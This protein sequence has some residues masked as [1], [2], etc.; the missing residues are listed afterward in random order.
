MQGEVERGG[1]LIR[2]REG[3]DFRFGV[4]TDAETGE[5]RTMATGTRQSRK[6]DLEIITNRRGGGEKRQTIRCVLR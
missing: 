6:S 4:G 1:G 5:F 3:E 2:E